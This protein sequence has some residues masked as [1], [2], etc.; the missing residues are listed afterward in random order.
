MSLFEK[1]EFR[2]EMD[3][4]FTGNVKELPWH[5]A[6]RY[7][8]VPFGDLLYVE[9]TDLKFFPGYQPDNEKNWKEWEEFNDEI[10]QDGKVLEE[11]DIEQGKADLISL[12]DERFVRFRH[13]GLLSYYTI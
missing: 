3:E 9:S 4:T 11:F 13:S 6:A 2:A 7:F 10:R 5:I 8:K 12:G 1:F